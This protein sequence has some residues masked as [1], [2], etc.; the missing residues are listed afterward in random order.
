LGS[1]G[2]ADAKTRS[3]KVGVVY[4]VQLMIAQI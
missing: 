1:Y 2:M 3:S 4:Q